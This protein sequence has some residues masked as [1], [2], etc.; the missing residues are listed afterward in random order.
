M[1]QILG[2]DVLRSTRLTLTRTAAGEYQFNGRGW[3]H[4]LGMSQ[5]GAICMAGPAYRKTYQE[6]LKHYYVG[7]RLAALDTVSASLPIP[8]LKPQRGF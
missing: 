4:G 2:Y 3:G 8:S 7:T 5:D 6:I 1:R